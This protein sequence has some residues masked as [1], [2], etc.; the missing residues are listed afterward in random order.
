MSDLKQQWIEA[1]RSGNYLQGKNWLADDMGTNVYYCCLG[2]LCEI[3]E[4]DKYIEGSVVYYD[5]R[6]Q[7]PPQ[8]LTFDVGL[9][10]VQVSSLVY[11]NDD[12]NKTFE[13][14]ADWIEENV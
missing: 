8:W 5:G 1:L 7:T 12:E 10:Q 6:D 13:E 3:A 4:L 14:I 9:T 11:M 2:V